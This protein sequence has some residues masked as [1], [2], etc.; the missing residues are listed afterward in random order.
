MALGSVRPVH[1]DL[2]VLHAGGDL[3]QHVVRDLRDLVLAQAVEHDDVVDAVEE[4]GAHCVLQL[5]HHVLLDLLKRALGVV[6]AALGKAQR[7]AALAGDLLRADVGGHDDDG[8]LE[9]DVAALTVGQ[10]AVLEDLQQDVEHIRMRLFDLIEQHDRV[11]MAAHLFGQLAALVIADIAR[12]RTD[13]AGDRMLF[14]VFRHIDADHGVLVAEH[15]FRE[16][17][18]QLGFA[19]AGRA[20][21]QER[22]DRTLGVAQADTAAADRLGDRSDGLILAD[23]ALMQRILEVQQA[24][25][26]ILGHLG[27]RHAGPARDHSR[28]VVRRDRAVRL[29]LLVRPFLFARFERI[30]LCFLLI[31]QLGG[32]LKV[33][34]LDRL[35]L[36]G[37]D[38]GDL[39][40][41]RLEVGRR[42]QCGQAHARARFVNHVDGLI[43][44]E[45]SG[46]IAHGHLDRGLDRVVRDLDAMMRLV[47]V[48]QA[49]EDGDCVLSGRLV[50]LHG[51][52]AALERGV[53]FDVL[54]VFIQRG[55][56]DDL[57]LAA[58]QRGFQDV[59]RVGRALGGARA[60]QHV[61]LIDK[62]DGILFGGQLFD[63]L[64]DALLELA[65][66]L[67]ARDH[68]G[69][70]ERDDALVLQGL[71]HVARDDL[72]RQAL[73]DRG[74]ADARI[75]DQR[76]VVL[77]AAGQDLDD[78]LD[79]LFAAD[80]RVELAFLGG[81]GQVA[82]ELVERVACGGCAA[83][84]ALARH[85]ALLCAAQRL[86]QLF[87]QHLR[88]HL[89][90]GQR[91]QRDVLALAQ[92]AEQQVLGAHIARA[93]LRG[94]LDRQLND[95][96]GAR[97]HALRGGGVRRAAAGQI[98]DLLDQRV[99]R[100]AR[101]GERLGS[102]AAALAQQAEQQVL[103]ADIAVS[104]RARGF[105]CLGQRL[106]GALGETVLIEHRSTLL[107]ELQSKMNVS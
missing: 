62:Q 106:L 30:A 49:L 1:G 21:E 56:A 87:D 50:D 9:V 15:G 2:H 34:R 17:L 91:G 65:A 76:R 7:L 31:A 105:L 95:A 5:S 14:H 28:N 51:L 70:V 78:A 104:E 58:A 102:R 83:R 60:H 25:A 73:D 36:L 88:G 84:R 46:H 24:L 27:D 12:R 22:A 37:G 71:G 54:A 23:Y 64:F 48:A 42:G 82:A 107:S 29:G 43:R 97:G 57:H 16:R 52:E 10:H 67:G 53:L 93:H 33:L 66:V 89:E 90:V 41:E 94:G 20:E 103:R 8:V 100:H 3:P 75:A 4:F 40:L 11:R 35:F 26:L 61:H 74:L 72:L 80:D 59:G 68:A 45:A 63:D 13:H 32:V 96:L 98:L 38:R 79:L 18:G 55:R 47:A 77:G 39:V 85:A 69:Q 101:G 86:L 44:Q 99:V 81:G 6:R 19:H 92:D